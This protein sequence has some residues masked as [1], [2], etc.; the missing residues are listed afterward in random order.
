MAHEHE[1][2]S[3]IFLTTTSQV[4]HIGPCI[5]HACLLSG[6][7]GNVNAQIFDGQNA[8]GVEKFHLEALSGTTF[9]WSS[10]DGVLF[11]KGIYITVGDANAH[12]MVEYHG[13]KKGGFP[14][15]IEQEN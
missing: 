1:A 3:T 2:L 10:A 6:D 7:G 4:V 9:G 11:H 14:P 15:I 8:N 5:I 12:T 13:I